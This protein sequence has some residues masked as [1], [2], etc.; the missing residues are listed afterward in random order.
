MGSLRIGGG[1]VARREMLTKTIVVAIL[2]LLTVVTT[3]PFIWMVLTSFQTTAETMRI[4]MQFWPE[5]FMMDNYNDLFGRFPF[6]TFFRNSVI[7]SVGITVP[8]V[9]LSSMAAYA[10][11][12][13]AFPGKNIIFLSMMAALM[14]PLQMILVPRFAL[15]GA[16]GWIN[17][18][19][20][21]IIP[22]TA[23][24]FA[25]FYLRQ[26]IMSIPRELDESAYLDGANH[27]TIYAF[28]IMPLLKSSLAAMT[29]LAVVFSW[30]NLLWPLIVLGTTANFTLPIGI[31]G[32]AGQ[33]GTPINLLMTGAVVSTLPMILVFLVGQ[34]YFIKGISTT[35]SKS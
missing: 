31:S 17:T 4:P 5:R 10:F 8:Q 1:T 23:S 25:T 22:T 26:S 19:R 18:L 15:M 13:I 29:V 12:R 20:G 33:F 2:L 16:F 30:N 11:A 3:L 34:E 6:A 28:I 14:V 27:F 35:G 7:V 24:I 21:V 9:I 32:L